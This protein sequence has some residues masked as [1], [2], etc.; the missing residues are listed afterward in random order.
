MTH[1]TFHENPIPINAIL[2]LAGFIAGI[3][4]VSF[5]TVQG[6]RHKA[7]EHGTD[8]EREQLLEVSDENE[9]GESDEGEV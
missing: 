5:V 4:L 7:Q 2:A 6:R 1:H 8:E 9:T 3:S